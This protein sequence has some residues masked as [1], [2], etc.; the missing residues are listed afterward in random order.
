MPKWAKIALGVAGGLAVFIAIVVAIVFYATSGVIDAIDRHL[1]LL[2]AG[3]VPTA[4]EET[5]EAFRSATTLEGFV[6]FIDAHPLLKE[7]EDHSFSSREIKNGVG[8]VSGKLTTGT[9]GV[10]PVEYRL[11]KENET[12]KILSI[13]LGG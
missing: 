11:V 2:K 3:D 9:G 7:I 8:H 12:W 1:A 10:L 5:S 4:Y 13:D 6:A